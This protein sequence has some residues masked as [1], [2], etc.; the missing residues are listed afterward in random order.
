MVR[1]RML[2]RLG[3]IATENYGMKR[4]SERDCRISL[5][6]RSVL[7]KMI[8]LAA[9]TVKSEPSNSQIGVYKFIVEAQ[10]R[11]ILCT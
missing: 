2:H 10:E 5:K 3:F 6:P 1:L 11:V 4:S 8:P 9:N 7:T